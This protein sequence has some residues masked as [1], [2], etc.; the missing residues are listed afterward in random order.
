MVEA[1][2]QTDRGDAVMTL[3]DSLAKAKAA[4]DKAEEDRMCI[5]R[6]THPVGKLRWAAEDAAD[7]VVSKHR[8][9]YESLMLALRILLV[10]EAAVKEEE[11]RMDAFHDLCEHEL[12]YLNDPDME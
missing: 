7:E 3:F 10:G 4:W 9:E 12:D 1:C 2:L 6:R 11:A 8:R 5:T